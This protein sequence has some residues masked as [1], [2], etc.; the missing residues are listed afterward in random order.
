MLSV[1]EM[2]DRL[3]ESDWIV[4]TPGG[5]FIDMTIPK[6][7][8]PA[9]MLVRPATDALKQV[10]EDRIVDSVSRDEVWSVEAFG[11]NRVVV[12]KLSGELT[13]EGLYGA[14]RATRLSWQVLEL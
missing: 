9:T 5:E 11:L 12:E 3:G 8:G 4:V 2:R 7:M 1:S 14:V 6:T 13:P 10:E